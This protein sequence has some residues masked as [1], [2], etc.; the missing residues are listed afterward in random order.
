MAISSMTAVMTWLLWPLIQ[1]HYLV[2]R[3]WLGM[4]RSKT[5]RP[6]SAT[7]LEVTVDPSHVKEGL[8]ILLIEGLFGFGHNSYWTGT[9]L[10][11]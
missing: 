10:L 8:P 1:L 2:W 7:S 3:K 11:H 9:S 5:L 4:G 6:Y